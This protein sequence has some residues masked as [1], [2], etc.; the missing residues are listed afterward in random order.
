[1]TISTKSP[2]EEKIFK[3]P[4]SILLSLIMVFSMFAIVPIASASAA[5]NAFV[6]V[7]SE[8]TDWSGEYLV[9]YEVNNEPNKVF[10]SAAYL[11]SGANT[12]QAE[13]GVSDGNID[14]DDTTAAAAVTI[15]K[16]EDT[17]Y[18]SIK[19]ASGKY[20]G[21]SNDTNGIDESESALNNTIAWD[22]GSVKITSAG[23]AIMRYNTSASQFRYYK[24]ATYTNQQPVQLY[25]LTVAEPE[26]ELAVGT[27][28]NS[29][30][31]DFADLNPGD[32]IAV[33]IEY[34]M[35]QDSVSS[36]I[37]KA[38]TYTDYPEGETAYDADFTAEDGMF[39]VSTNTV[40]GIL[41]FD[42]WME[43][44]AFMP[45]VDGAR[46]N[47][48]YVE[49]IENGVVTLSGANLPAAP[50]ETVDIIADS[51]NAFVDWAYDSETTNWH[52]LAMFE[53][54]DSVYLS[55][56]ADTQVA[57]TYT[58]ADM[59]QCI[60]TYENTDYTAKTCSITVAVDGDIVTTTGTIVTNEGLTFN[61]NITYAPEPA[62]GEAD[63]TFSEDTTFDNGLTVDTEV[64]EIAEDVTVTV[65]GGLVITGELTVE[66]KG[67]LVVNGADG[68]NG[69]DGRDGQDGSDGDDASRGGNGGHAV[70]GNIIIDGVTV[71]AY[72]GDGGNG[73]NGGKGAKG[74][75]G[76][77]YD[78][79]E[80]GAD[81]GIGGD[82]GAHYEW[83]P[84]DQYYYEDERADDGTPGA[85]GYPGSAGDAGMAFASAPVV[86]VAHTVQGGSS[87]MD[88]T[89]VQDP[90]AYR[91]VIVT[92]TASEPADPA[93]DVAALINALPAEIT[94][95]DK[96]AVEEARAAYDALTDDQKALIDLPT[97]TLLT[98]AEER[99]AD[100]EAAAAV[101][102]LINALPAAADVAITDANDIIA[103]RQAY[104]ALTQPQKFLIDS[105][106]YMKLVDAEL[107]SQ[108]IA[109]DVNAVSGVVTQIE[110]LPAASD[111]TLAD[112][113]DINA[114]RM[115]YD[116]L[117]DSQKAMFPGQA[118]QKLTD[119][120]A[121]IADLEAA[122]AVA[123]AINA[124]PDEITIYDKQNVE[125][126]R[127]AY[128]A[129]TDAQKAL[130]DADTLQ[131]LTHAEAAI[132]D[133]EAAG[134]VEA[135][136]DA[137]PAEIT[138][139]DKTNVEAAR[140]AYDALTDAQKDLIDADTLQKLTDAETALAAAE[141]AA[142]DQ[143]A[144]DAVVDAFN[145]LPTEVTVDDKD[146]IEA[147]RAAY[148][149][150]T[151]DQKALIDDETLAKL[152][153]AEAA[154]DALPLFGDVDGD[155]KVDIFDASAIQKSLAGVKDY[156]N[157]NKMDKNDIAFRIADIDGD[158]KVDIFDASL[159]Q[160]WVAGDAAAQGLGIGAKF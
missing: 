61:V 136:I 126:A 102:T 70:T 18:Y 78:F 84:D 143:T 145:A 47:A 99:I 19:T 117:T 132:A 5:E 134:A 1:M 100:L 130:I 147:A 85:P 56:Y 7:T 13:F 155:G 105:E 30:E 32:Y 148:D 72:G 54:D 113:M 52:M 125:S 59:D 62:E 146:T 24:T 33:G 50:A 90:T 15:A 141:K 115:A 29:G 16:I 65:N 89:D 131:K 23:G 106:T 51:T 129:L 26:P 75:D 120:E 109:D 96:E 9:V 114:A 81:G 76:Y 157:Y 20:I 44:N 14:Y 49:S 154:Y 144:A 2:K 137:L 41:C 55:S 4:V 108:Q 156:P 149:A 95:D 35:D 140:A 45:L 36:L 111:V 83:E 98:N 79:P 42:D 74:D 128:D 87:Q 37:L 12:L 17:G 151:D 135:L 43:G 101:E 77:D 40:Y 68:A 153:D 127:E 66:G 27:I 94:L 160:K 112:E 67:T 92:V 82:G 88:I 21:R 121:A 11:A 71:Y 80:N 6:K 28:Y 159:I 60:V 103:A 86:D 133:L 107:A 38:G 31:L 8:P 124:L 39:D 3:K 139:A 73:G 119:A 48:F 46:A 64:W 22:N 69:S 142:A 118:L 34:C 97:L 104:D 110:D 116:M 25:K 158:G 10:N 152:T 122:G 63:R 57:G 138:L 93:A 123:T 91:Y 53:N 58:E 150:L